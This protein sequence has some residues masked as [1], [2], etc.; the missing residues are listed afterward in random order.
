MGQ[1]NKAMSTKNPKSNDLR[2]WSR[3]PEGLTFKGRDWKTYFL[4]QECYL[5][6][7]PSGN[8]RLSWILGKSL[9]PFFVLIFHSNWVGYFSSSKYGDPSLRFKV[10]RWNKTLRCGETDY[11]SFHYR[12]VSSLRVLGGFLTETYRKTPVWNYSVSP[13]ENCL[14]LIFIT[15]ERLINSK[16]TRF[17]IF[18]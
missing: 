8:T 1:K 3:I 11:A 17:S 2:V 10:Q 14:F 16:T 7:L 6:S 18:S 5:F 4:W 9:F 13:V 12:A 15:A